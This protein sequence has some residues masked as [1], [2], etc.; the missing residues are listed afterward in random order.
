M[1]T[2]LTDQIENDQ[3]ARRFRMPYQITTTKYQS[4]EDDYQVLAVG[5]IDGAIILIDLIL[6]V[7]K[8]FFEK[9]PSAI[10]SMAFYQDKA[11]ISGS[12]CGRVNISDI[13]NVSSNKDAPSTTHTKFWKA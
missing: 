8:H 11:L 5:L 1:K 12:I 10:S 6:G 9:H 3:P 4:L 13:E 7:E 2:T